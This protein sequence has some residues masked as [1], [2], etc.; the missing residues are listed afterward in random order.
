[1]VIIG[2]DVYYY[3]IILFYKRIKDLITVKGAII[4]RVNIN[5]ITQ[6]KGLIYL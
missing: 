3:N 4:V 6:E 2:K 1:V 5:T